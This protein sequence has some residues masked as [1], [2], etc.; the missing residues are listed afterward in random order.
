M[1]TEEHFKKKN[2]T[3]KII[4]IV[5][6]L[7]VMTAGMVLGFIPSLRPEVSEYEKR[8]LTAFPSYTS[9]SFL[10]GSYTKGIALYYADTYPFRDFLLET[11][12]RIKTFYGL[13]GDTITHTGGDHTDW[14]ALLKSLEEEASKAASS[15]ESQSESEPQSESESESSTNPTENPPVTPVD[16]KEIHVPANAGSVNIYNHAGYCVSGFL[17]AAANIYC[18]NVASVAKNLPNV[19]VYQ[20]IIPDNSAITLPDSVQKE[21]GLPEEDKVVMY[22]NMKT[23]SLCPSVHTVSIYDTLRD[24]RNEYLYFRT[25]HHWT[26]LG[27]YYA[28]R[29]FCE[30]AGLTGHNLNEYQTIVMENFTGSYVTA[31]KLAELENYPDT[32]T[33]YIPLSGNTFQFYDTTQETYRTGNIVREISAEYRHSSYSAFIYGDNPISLIT[34]SSCKNHRKAILVKESFGNAFAPFL[35]D[36]FEE[37]YI[38]DY[39]HYKDSIIKLAKEKGIT[40]ILFINNI[41]AISH[42]PTMENMGKLCVP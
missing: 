10:D 16:P 6:F 1:V 9:E 11:E 13:P 2:Q 8:K 7:L 37:V 22:Y 33:A 20:M 19:A 38:I 32:L 4:G 14:E 28:Y 39:R 34:N 42:V 26:Q 31:S 29:K 25:D 18:E 36:E 17:P 5:S 23:L 40:D 21:W 15:S 12:Q 24:H 30:S 27:A 41:E 3:R 35:A